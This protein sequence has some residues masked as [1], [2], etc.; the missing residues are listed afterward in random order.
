MPGVP[1]IERLCADA[2][3]AAERKIEACISERLAA[4]M[5]DKLDDM[6]SETV[7]GSIS[8]FI[9][10]RQFEVGNNSADMNRVLD[11][12]EFLQGLGLTPAVTVRSDCPAAG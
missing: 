3:L 11:M 5:R 6:L 9:W 12:L 10:L 4:A 7:E 8:R 1:L 2:L